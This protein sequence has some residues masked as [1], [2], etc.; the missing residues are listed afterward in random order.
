MRDTYH[1]YTDLAWLWP[2][3][4]YAASEYA[5]YCQHVTS[6]VRQYGERPATTL[7]NIGC[8]GGKNVLNRLQ[9]RSSVMQ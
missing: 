6:L 1:L 9:V 7:L 2:I 3:W 8:G 4:G 5:H